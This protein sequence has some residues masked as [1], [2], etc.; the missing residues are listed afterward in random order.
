MDKLCVSEIPPPPSGKKAWPWILDNSSSHGHEFVGSPWPRITVVTPSFNQADYLEETIRSVLAQNYPNL[1]YIVMDGGSTDGSRDIIQKYAGC[2]SFWVSEKDHGQTDALNRGFARSNGQIL[3]WLNS[4]DIYT[5]GSLL[6]VANYFSEHPDIDVLY[7]PCDL[8]DETS[9]FIAKVN[10]PEFD[11]AREISSNFLSQ[12][13]TFFR[14]SVLHTIGGFNPTRHYAFDYEFWLQ[15]AI[16]GFHFASLPGPSLAMFRMWQ[17]SK[18]EFNTERF[19]PETISIL[20]EVF[21]SPHFPKKYQGLQHKA[22]SGA[23]RFAAFG[24]FR[25]GQMQKTRRYLRKSIG[26]S[27]REIFNTELILLY[28]RSFLGKSFNNFTRRLKRWLV[29]VFHNPSR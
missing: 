28:L 16:R 11:L 23:W 10:P 8:I 7:G 19:I 17:E 2:I 22:L 3:A 14:Q 4:D 15:A 26:L 6:R 27:P 25:T 21:A 9:H 20:E 29:R 1:E 13:A 24:A 18:S 5:P 12:P